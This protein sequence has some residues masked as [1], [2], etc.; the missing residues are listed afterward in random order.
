M[1]N[2]RILVVDDEEDIIKLIKYNLEKEGFKVF[3]ADTGEAAE[4]IAVRRRRVGLKP[5]KP[6][7]ASSQR[8][9]RSGLIAK[10]SSITRSTL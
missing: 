5:A 1:S 8:N 10:H 9:T 3:C 2:E 6:Y 7:Q 4:R